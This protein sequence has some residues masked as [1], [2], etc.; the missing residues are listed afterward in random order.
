MKPLSVFIIDD[1]EIYQFIVKKTI[2]KIDG[3]CEAT[4]FLN[5]QDAINHFVLNNTGATGVPDVVLL[6][7]NMPVMDGWEFLDQYQKLPPTPGGKT[8]M[9]VVSSSI[10]A[11]DKEKALSYPAVADFLSKPLNTTTLASLLAVAPVV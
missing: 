2:Q 8:R 1:D 6:D 4:S 9:Y 11:E 3:N 10:S 5:G 7:I